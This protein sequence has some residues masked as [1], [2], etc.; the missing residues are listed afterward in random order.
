M[1]HIRRANI[2]YG[3][4][5]DFHMLLPAVAGKIFNIP[6][7]V[8]MGGFDGMNIP[9][10]NHGLFISKW[11]ARVARY[12]FK[13][14]SL[15][16]PVTDK[17]ILSENKYT[18]W[19]DKRTFG[20]KNEIPELKT[21]I[22][23]LPTGY[24][25]GAWTNSIQKRKKIV[26]TTALIDIWRKVWIKGIDLFIDTARVMPDVEFRLIGV[27]KKM[28]EEIIARFKPTSN[29]TF[30]QPVKREEL[31][32]LY[33]EASVYAQLSRVEGLPN[34]LCEAM[35]CG[36]IPVGSS[37]FGIPDAVN[38]VGYL[39]D[40]PEPETIKNSILSALDATEDE[41]LKVREYIEHNFSLKKRED[42]LYRIIESNL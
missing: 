36:C 31:N 5:V 18:L 12:I 13:H 42:N 41:R 16:L 32:S 8:C 27:S 34:V 26:C 9:E 11:R 19:P 20:L 25:S 40:Q 10:L 4:F 1:K 3:W 21:S 6:V 14:I 38:G 23:V 33:H 39:V 37:V 22:Q 15:L 24:N 28:E 30:L 17:I 7:I 35:L 29:V 2:I